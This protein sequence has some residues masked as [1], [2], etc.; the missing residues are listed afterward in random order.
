MECL[1]EQEEN[2]K[3]EDL[4]DDNVEFNDSDLEL[5]FDDYLAKKAIER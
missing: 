3:L 2:F 5:N 4:P 1:E